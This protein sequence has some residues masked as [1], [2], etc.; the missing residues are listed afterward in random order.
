V[1][2]NSSCFWETGMQYPQ[3]KILWYKDAQTLHFSNNCTGT[4]SSAF[5]F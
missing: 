5:D 2:E 1:Q 4:V 3:C